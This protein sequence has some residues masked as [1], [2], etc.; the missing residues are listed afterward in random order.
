MRGY[1]ECIDVCSLKV[2]KFEG[3]LVRKFKRVL[4][5]VL[6]LT[7]VLNLLTVNLWAIGL[8]LSG[9]GIKVCETYLRL[10]CYL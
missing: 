8:L 7:L 3:S 4:A 5:V 6:T 2:Y 1:Q 9:I 10:L